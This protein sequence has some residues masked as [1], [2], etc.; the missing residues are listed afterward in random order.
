MIPGAQ[1]SP[2]FAR[3]IHGHYVS[4][5]KLGQAWWRLCSSEDVPTPGLARAV[6]TWRP[7]AK[8]EKWARCRAACK[9][10]LRQQQQQQ[11]QQQFSLRPLYTYHDRVR[12]RVRDAY[13]KTCHDFSR[14][15]FVFCVDKRDPFLLCYR[16]FTLCVAS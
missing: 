2:A 4:Y 7:Y 5:R 6:T 14:S 13:L 16:N 12:Q 3:D 11:Q 8:A 15:L 10:S 9:R 1:C